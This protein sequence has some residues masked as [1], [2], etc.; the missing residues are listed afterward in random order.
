MK[1]VRHWLDPALSREHREREREA[2]L[3]VSGAVRDIGADA[4]GAGVVAA[5]VVPVVVR[6]GVE[7][8][9]ECE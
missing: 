5:L 8:R 6:E 4:A 7:V 9:A 1:S 3:R 2:E